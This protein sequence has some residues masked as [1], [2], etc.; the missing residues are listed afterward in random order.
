MVSN[1]DEVTKV[2]GG[3]IQA[4]EEPL[5]PAMVIADR[6]FI[7]KVTTRVAPPVWN[8]NSSAKAGNCILHAE[9]P[10]FVV[11]PAYAEFFTFGSL[12]QVTIFCCSRSHQAFATIPWLAG[13]DPVEIVEWPGQ[14]SVAA[15][16]YAAARN[17]AP[18]VSSR[19]SPPVHCPRNLS[20]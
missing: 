9:S 1:T 19:F 11:P 20:T 16:G 6:A 12:V 18:S 8:F 7:E 13:N 5:C 3:S 10:P 15:Y 17:Q 2:P 14:V 4:A